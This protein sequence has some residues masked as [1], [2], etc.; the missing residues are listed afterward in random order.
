M[1]TKFIRNR[2]V[3][4]ILLGIM[5]ALVPLGYANAA[6]NDY[7]NNRGQVRDEIRQFQ[8]F[9][10]DHPKVS[11]ELQANPQ[12]VYNR[13]YLD[14]HEDLSKFLRRHPAVQQEVANNPERVFGRY[15][16]NDRGYGPFDGLG[17]WARGWGWGR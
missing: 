12:L 6:W 17:D 16:A 11:T 10:Q 4:S 1:K 8:A 14:R 9:L 13:K 3:A 2:S 7:R 5:V 15:Y